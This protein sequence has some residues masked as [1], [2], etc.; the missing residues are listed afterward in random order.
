M[1]FKAE[2]LERTEAAEQVVFSFLPEEEG[3]QKTIFSAMNYSVQAPG[4]RLRPILMEETFRMFGGRNEAV[5]HHFMAA[6][7]FIHTYS[8]VHDDLPAM[9]NDEYRRGRKTTHKVYGEAMGILAGDALLHHAFDT[10]AGSFLLADVDLG[11]A[12]KAL[13]ILTEKSGINGMVGGQVV[14]VEMEGKTLNDEQLDF[15]YR[16]KT[17]A[18]LECAMMIGA[19]LAGADENT[20]S[21]I[22]MI[23]N[24]VGIAFQIQDDILDR[25]SSTEELGKPVGSDEKNHKMTYVVLHGL[26]DSEKEVER[27]SREA[28][29]LLDSFE[30]EHTFLKELIVSLIHRRK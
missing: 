30:Q 6:L 12:G 1:E 23:A 29:E 10:A 4:K 11:A 9:D 25:I 15:I 20:V 8:L 21:R 26:E 13:K 7:E 3:L 28:V 22:E 16:L 27:L 5:L 14:D 17:A 2:L 24:R 19:T 18:L